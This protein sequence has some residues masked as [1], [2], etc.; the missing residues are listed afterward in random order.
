M[1]TSE[2]IEGLALPVASKADKSFLRTPVELK[3]DR[4]P[5][6]EWGRTVIVR[7]MT[8]AE[9][10]DYQ[11]SN[12]KFDKGGNPRGMQKEDLDL[13]LLLRTCVDEQGVRVFSED[14]FGLLRKQPASLINRLVRPAKRL[15]ALVDENDDLEPEERIEVEKND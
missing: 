4:V 13:R 3:Q 8:A 15:S 12:I 6:P 1:D 5:M 11:M 2:K 14:D 9:N 10:R 7:E